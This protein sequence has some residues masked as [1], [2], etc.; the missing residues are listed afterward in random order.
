MSGAAIAQLQSQAQQ[1]IEDLKNNFK[2]MKIK[3]GR[4]LAQFYKLFYY[5]KE[6]TF[7]TDV[8]NL[9]QNGASTL[10]ALGRP[11]MSKEMAVG[12]F[13]GSDYIDVEFDVV[14]EAITGAKASTVGDINII[15]TFFAKGAIDLE[16]FIECYP[17]DSLSNKSELLSRI[18]EAK[19][20]QIAQLQS[21]VQQLTQLVQQYEARIAESERTVSAANSLIE[22]NKR[23]KSSLVELYA[24]ATARI[25]MA[26]EQI[27]LGNQRIIETTRDAQTMARILDGVD[28]IGQGEPT[29]EDMV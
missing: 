9:D 22:E 27:K 2:L 5:A 20:G 10:D 3:Q 17:D 7:E 12:T 4:V 6:Y 24:E 23:L 8:S 11:V 1:P 13:N 25:N 15:E 16:T 19:T 29:P 26:N 14:V 18:R 28:H 21:Q